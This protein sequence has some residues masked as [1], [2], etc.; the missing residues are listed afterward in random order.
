MKLKNLVQSTY[1]FLWGGNMPSSMIHLL[2]AHKYHPEASVLFRIGNIAPDS[3]SEREE[4]DKT[5]LRNR[6][7]RLNALRELALTMDLSDDFSKGILL[8]LFLDYYWDSSPMR[9]FIENHKDGNWF[10]DYRNE[11]GIASA[12]LF[13]HIG[14]SR[15][16][17]DEMAACPMSAYGHVQW[18]VKEDVADFIDRNN[19]WHAEND[20]GPSSAFTPDFIEEFTDKV[21]AE[22]KNWLKDIC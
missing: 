6:P 8:H 10:F 19:K 2:T 5:H 7:D 9:N 15:R 12:W 21:A 14:W 20:I 1:Y 16:A 18:I 4:K 3:V 22:F 17:W 13:H 11:I